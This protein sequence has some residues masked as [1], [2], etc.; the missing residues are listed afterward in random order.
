[1]LVLSRKPNEEILIGDNIRVTVV[2]IQGRQ[3]RLGFSAPSNVSIFRSELLETND[4]VNAADSE[5]R[6]QSRTNLDINGF[7]RR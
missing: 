2:S 6:V 4:Q 3:V 5:V 7:V 1:M